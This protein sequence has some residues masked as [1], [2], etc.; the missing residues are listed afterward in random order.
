MVPPARPDTGH[1]EV[2]LERSLLVQRLV[3]PAGPERFPLYF[4]HAPLASGGAADPE[5]T[6]TALR[7]PPQTRVSFGTLFNHFPE[8]YWRQWT[9][10]AALAFDVRLDGS[11]TLRLWRLP[12]NV[13]AVLEAPWPDGDRGATL[14]AS[15]RFEG[16]DEPVR[17]EVPESPGG[18]RGWGALQV[19]LLTGDDWVEL[20]D[21][22]WITGAPVRPVRLAV[23]F[24]TF[25]RPAEVL[26]NTR[27]LLDDEGSRAFI[28]RVFII[29]QGT[30]PV[31]E[32]PDFLPLRA[33]HGAV[34]QL[35]EQG[36]HGGAGG[37]TR[38]I[39]E[40]RAQGRTS[41]MLLMDDD[42]EL[43]PESVRRCAMFLATGREPLAVGGQMLNAHRPRE[44]VEAGGLYNRRTIRIEATAWR[45]PEASATG[46]TFVD[47]N[48]WWFFAFPLHAV[49]E[50]GLPLPLFIRGDD[51]EFGLRLKAH[52]VPTVTLPGIAV[53][54]EP[55]YCKEGGWTG[56]Y[57][58][59]NLLVL[60]ALHGRPG[61]LTPSLMVVQWVFGRLLRLDYY[62][63]WLFEQAAREFLAGPEAI[64]ADAT[65]TRLRVAAA[66]DRLRGRPMR[67]GE[68]I[69]PRARR[70][71][72]ARSLAGW[73]LL[74]ARN[75]ARNLILP[76]PRS[77]TAPRCSLPSDAP[78]W[79]IARHDVVAFDDPNQM[80]VEVRRRDRGRFLAIAAAALGHAA[81]LALSYPRLRRRYRDAARDWSGEMFWSAHLRADAD[82]DAGDAVRPVPED[83]GDT[84]VAIETA[85]TGGTHHVSR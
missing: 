11:G 7:V 48:A 59:R 36:N 31:R 15:R 60:A 64:V 30:R 74:I 24:T 3:F 57:D 77:G 39:I 52:R 2:E 1:G 55:F 25:N 8:I 75:I 65:T 53:W 33:R 18:W 78:W 4:R 54:H 26:A 67:R 14:L 76:S 32:H 35:I 81:R 68:E 63:A 41:H 22:G 17:L 43:E 46:I 13:D 47:Y 28:E 85:G 70:R 80:Q 20:R 29:D 21:G 66:A 38:A 58:L 73:G 10:A 9:H 72:G 51:I 37:F 83:Q 49:A 27:C 61:R 62:S 45:R 40:A 84:A 16:T 12:Y 23:G 19:E 6:R 5:V 56:Y 50:T 82:G 69:L 42:A 34:V 44:L 71:P 79:D